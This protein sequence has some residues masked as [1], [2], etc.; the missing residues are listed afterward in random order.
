[1]AGVDDFAVARVG[2][3]G[4]H[5]EARAVLDVEQ[6]ARLGAVALDEQGLAGQVA[7]DEDGHHAPLGVP[8]LKRA[9]GVERPDDLGR[10]LVGVVVG[11]HQVFGRDLAGPVGRDGARRVGLVDAAA[12]LSA[13]SS[14]RT[15]CIFGTKISP[16]WDATAAA[17]TRSTA[18]AQVM[19][20][21]VI[22]GAVSVSGPPARSAARRRGRR[23]RP[24]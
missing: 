7:G 18:S 16:P 17:N 4:P 21:R 11:Q 2:R 10:H 9:V 14:R 19:K 23:C 1:M 8:L 15:A 3:A 24:S 20:N 5:H 12:V 22:S 13:R 6:V